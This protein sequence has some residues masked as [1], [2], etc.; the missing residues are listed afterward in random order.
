MILALFLL[1]FPVGERLE[2][3][4]RFSFLNLGIM[5]LEV[6]D[7]MIY[8]GQHCYVISSVLNSARSL[9]FLFSIDDTIDVYTSSAQMLPLLYRE[10]INESGYHRAGNLYFDR[11][12]R[13]VSYDDSLRI[14]ILEDTRDVLSFW[15]YLRSVPMDVGDTIRVSVHNAQE[16]HDVR[17]LVKSRQKIKTNAGEYNTILVEPETLGKGIFGA[18]GGMEI[19]YSENDRLPVQIRASMK[20]GSVLFKLREVQY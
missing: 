20:F 10:R 13:T 6:K 9:R 15:Y 8:E 3:E 4:A 5:T 2:Y 14:E 12:K 7:T 1:A 11:E 17:C 16:N 18:K 19:W